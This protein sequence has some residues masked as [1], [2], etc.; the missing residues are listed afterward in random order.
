MADEHGEILEK[1]MG[2]IMHGG[3]AKSS[4]ME[5]I[6]AAKSGDFDGAEDKL[7]DSEEALTKAHKFQTN[8]LTKEASGD[9]VELSL[10]MVHGQDHLMTAMTVKD[11]ATEIIDVYRKLDGQEV[12]LD[13][14]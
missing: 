14:E 1:V 7:A 11:L 10:L 5:A 3:D 9:A 12:F 13:Q 6:H 8:L 4:A 2:L